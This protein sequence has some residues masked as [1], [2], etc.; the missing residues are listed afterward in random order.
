MQAISDKLL[1]I[2]NKVKELLE[3]LVLLRR[4]NNTL[5][6]EH[7][8]LT[9]IID[10]QKESLKELESKLLA[11]NMHIRD[12]GDQEA[13]KKKLEHYIEEIDKCIEMVNAIE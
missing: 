10:R 4:E 9:A 8:N 3:E 7:E 1:R 5:K 12:K 13:V 2:E 6:Q 11:E